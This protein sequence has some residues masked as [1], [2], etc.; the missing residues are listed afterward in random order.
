MRLLAP[1]FL[2]LLFASPALAVDLTPKELAGCQV[3]IFAGATIGSELENTFENGNITLES[4]TGQINLIWFPGASA[5]LTEETLK[6]Y[7]GALSDSGAWFGMDSVRWTTVEGEAA[8]LVPVKIG[9]SE[10]PQTGLLLLWAS[11]ATGRYMMYI[12]T[13]KTKGTKTL[14][15]D[16]DLATAL[17]GVAAGISCVGAGE[18]KIPLAVIDPV[19]NGWRE[20]SGALPRI[21]YTKQ[22]RGQHILLWSDRL[23]T[24][25]YSCADLAKPNMMRFAEARKLTIGTVNVVVD[26]ATGEAGGSYLCHVTA[27]VEGWSEAA[28]D[29]LSFAQWVCPNEATRI[30]SALEVAGGGLDQRLDPMT[31]ANCLEDLP[32]RTAAAEPETPAEVKEQWVPTAPPPKKKKKKTKKK[33]K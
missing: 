26:D 25:T 4:R 16:A 15:S 30:V 7:T 32:E 8:A 12:A 14:I 22:D 29:T 2:A 19:P 11:T 5:E 10:Q 13:P 17:D 3:P 20:D 21:L 27:P 24:T 23:P 28:G 33:K 9:G 18:V 1:I 31:A 6:L